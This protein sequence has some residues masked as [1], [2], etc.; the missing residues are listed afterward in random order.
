LT[1]DSLDNKRHTPQRVA[2]IM[3]PAMHPTS[4][5][6]GLACLG[7]YM[8]EQGAPVEVRLFDLNLSYHKQV[9][10]WLEDGRLKV[11]MRG[12]DHAGTVRN[13]THACRFLQGGAGID[14]FLDLELYNKH[15]GVYSD[16][17]G[18]VN[19]LFENF[20][21]RLLCGLSLPPLAKEF[22]AELFAPVR[23]FEPDL[24]GISLL[25][26]QQLYFGFAVAEAL[27]QS[28]TSVVLGGATL[29]V[30]PEPEKLLQEPVQTRIGK[31][32]HRIEAS[33][34][35]DFLLPGEGEVG[36]SALIAHWQGDLSRVPGLI[37]T[38]NG[39]VRHNTPE[40]IDNLDNLPLPD[41]SQFDLSCYYTPKPVL[42]YLS[43]RGCFWQ[44]CA[45]CTHR[46]TYLAYREETIEATVRRLLLLKERYGAS[47]FTLADEMVHPKR[48]GKLAK[49]IIRAGLDIR[50]SAY[51]KPTASFDRPLLEGIYRSGARV[52]MWGVES[53]SRRVLDQMGKGTCPQ[54]MEQV[55]QEAGAS[56]I[57]NLVFVMFGFP[58]ETREEWHE[59]LDFLGRV[60]PHIHAL[61]KARFLLLAGSDVFTHPEK[62]NIKRVMPRHGRDPISIAYDFEVTGG[63]SA[64]EARR[65]YGD[66]LPRLRQF[67]ISPWLGTFRDHMLIHAAES[68]CS[69]SICAS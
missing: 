25:F 61:S 4:P 37:Y 38:R 48:F 44:R 52:L 51:A 39:E 49:E 43:A 28:G 60:K 14:S 32:A 13:V 2:L 54:D 58:G 29:S 45:F 31:D 18:I 63:L 16:F 33:R 23:D 64:M 30:M 41:F 50:Y 62:Y 47:H 27:K 22:L 11:K 46:K 5:P 40:A 21:R 15:A 6:L 24:A 53:G 8:K 65:L 1:A 10:K 35:I 36:L 7:A 56:G 19:G 68:G 26:S 69:R 34:F 55:L 9:M 59:T 20:S 17:D 3:P 67:G 57:W 12:W 42:S 66:Q